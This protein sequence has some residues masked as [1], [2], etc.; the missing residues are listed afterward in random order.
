MHSNGAKLREPRFNL[1]VRKYFLTV[2]TP[3][4]SEWDDVSTGISIPV[5]ITFHCRQSEG[6]QTLEVD[7]PKP[8]VL[9]PKVNNTKSINGTFSVW[10]E[11]TSGV[12]QGSV[13][14]PVFFNIFINDLDEEVQGKKII[15]ADDTKLGG[16]ANTLED[17]M[18]IQDE[19]GGCLLHSCQ[20]AKESIQPL[21][22][23]TIPN[24]FLQFLSKEMGHV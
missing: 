22:L 24:R 2:R 4:E 17:R 7:G 19:E 15:F 10:M 1:D 12:P 14:G 21:L 5:K 9:R 3:G 16:I 6:D 13:L 11:I 23:A 8:V 18:N 20:S